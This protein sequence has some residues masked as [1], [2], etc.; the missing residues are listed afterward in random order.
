MLGAGT[1]MEV[2]GSIA[3]G[4]AVTSV[5]KTA[6]CVEAASV[7]GSP[8]EVDTAAPISELRAQAFVGSGKIEMGFLALV[9][10][11]V[12]AKYL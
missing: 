11:L 1:A 10:Q 3:V 9:L 5:E 7:A 6:Q 12:S 4:D 2:A 8:D